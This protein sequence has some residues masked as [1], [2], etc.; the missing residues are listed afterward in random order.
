MWN[1]SM[2]QKQNKQSRHLAFT[3][4]EK[5]RRTPSLNASGVVVQSEPIRFALH[6]RTCDKQK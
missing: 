4:I 6:G 5:K 1:K 2:E 3:V